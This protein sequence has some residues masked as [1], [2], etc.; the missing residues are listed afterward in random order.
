MPEIGRPEL[1]VNCFRGNGETLQS[2]LYS[3]LPIL[4]MTLFQISKCHVDHSSLFR[5]KSE[6][7]EL[8]FLNGLKAAAPDVFRFRFIAMIEDV[9]QFVLRVDW[10]EALSPPSNGRGRFVGYS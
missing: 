8:R 3:N 9:F 5:R 7:C 10:P 1:V 6:I 2:Q 4:I